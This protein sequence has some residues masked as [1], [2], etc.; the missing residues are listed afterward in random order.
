MEDPEV[1]E[2]ENAEGNEEE[3]QEPT[4]EEVQRVQYL[5]PEGG[6]SNP[7]DGLIAEKKAMMSQSPIHVNSLPSKM[8]LEA[9]VVPTVMQAL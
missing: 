7:D 9:T 6:Y 3:K 2:Q 4:Y 5:D 1:A 8:Y